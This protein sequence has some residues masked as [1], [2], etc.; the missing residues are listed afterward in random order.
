MGHR[1]DLLAGARRCLEERGYARTTA[2]DL[3]AASGTNLASIGYH[4]GS[5]DALLV[6][7]MTE[8]FDE[9][10]VQIR[11]AA[12]NS[13]P[14]G[15]DPLTLLI[16]SWGAMVEVCTR[17]RGLSLAYSEAVA[18][19][20]HQPA[21]QAQLATIYQRSRVDVA[22]L[23]KGVLPT[24]SD[25]HAAAL[26]SFEIAVCDGLVVQWLMDPDGMPRG[27]ELVAAFNA[28]LRALSRA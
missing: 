6:A 13:A 27:D 8:L 22:E 2:R 4:F 18:F 19:A 5:K 11:D 16:A 23:I 9:W 20:R 21:L 25:P 24:L 14:P 12:L 7:A 26:A 17:H 1:E 15:S 28:A 10:A 3:V